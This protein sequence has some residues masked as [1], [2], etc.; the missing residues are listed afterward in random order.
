M[1]AGKPLNLA[2]QSIGGRPGLATRH[3]GKPSPSFDVGSV[4]YFPPT[5]FSATTPYVFRAPKA[6]FWKLVGWSAG[7]G[8]NSGFVASGAGPSGSYG[9][10]TAYLNPGQT[11]AITI[12]F[13]SFNVTG[14]NTTIGFPDGS[15]MTLTAADGTISAVGTAIGGDVNLNGS[16]VSGGIGVAGLGTG[17]GAGGGASGGCGAPGMLPFRGGVGSTGH[18]AGIGAG[19][20]ASGS[21]GLFGGDSL[22]LA[23]FVRD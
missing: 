2:R 17:G 14:A 6:G 12:G 15:S 16:A 5:S 8:S 4:F 13:P 11:V 23:Y 20:A 21:G 7:A 22:V 19:C 9:E 10:K 1:A 3:I 18:A